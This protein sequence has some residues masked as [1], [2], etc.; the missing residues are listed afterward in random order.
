M[1]A[2]GAALVIR[3]RNVVE[4]DPVIR[5]FQVGWHD[6]HKEQ[7]GADLLALLEKHGENR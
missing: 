3:T 2:N 7:L 6:T 4:D 1:K 5:G